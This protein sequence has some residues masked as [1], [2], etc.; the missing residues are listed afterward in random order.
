MIE[1]HVQ[2]W[3][4][5]EEECWGL[6]RWDYWRKQSRALL[7]CYSRHWSAEKVSGGWCVF[8]L[9]GCQL[10]PLCLL[11]NLLIVLHYG[12][13]NFYVLRSSPFKS[14][15]GLSPKVANKSSIKLQFLSWIL[16]HPCVVKYIISVTSFSWTFIECSLVTQIT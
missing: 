6:L 8:S 12:T 11:S 7:C 15:E 4:W 9:I 14:K 16:W 5:E 2:M 10:L 13:W 3:S 1:L